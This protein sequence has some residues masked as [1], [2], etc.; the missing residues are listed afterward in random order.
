M[1]EIG[2]ISRL[3]RQDDFYLNE[4]PA[5]MRVIWPRLKS[6]TWFLKNHRSRL[7][8]EGALIRLGR[9]YFIEADRFAHVALAIL[10][11]PNQCALDRPSATGPTEMMDALLSRGAA[12]ADLPAQH[13]S[14]G[15]SGAC[16]S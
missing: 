6:F 2:N 8:T 7:K 16:V 1:M 14:H 10:G 3:R 9:D 5:W 4:A 12:I 13:D 15:E 11:I